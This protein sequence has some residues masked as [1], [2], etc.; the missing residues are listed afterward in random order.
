V[1]YMEAETIACGQVAIGI[2][3]HLMSPSSWRNG[4]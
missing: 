3:E 2:F 4:L 1:A